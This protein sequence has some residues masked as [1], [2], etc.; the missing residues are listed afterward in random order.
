MLIFSV[1][2]GLAASACGSE[3]T[4]DETIRLW[5]SPERVECEGGAGPQECLVV[6]RSE[7]GATELFYDSIDGFSFEEGTSYVIDVS[8]SEVENPPAD[9]SSIR[10][11]LVEVVSA[12]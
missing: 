4:S 7:D 3:D 1:L 10:Y 2:A 9:G 11:T 5:I 8:T 12:D 6:A